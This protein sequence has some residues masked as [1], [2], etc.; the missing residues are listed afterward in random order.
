MQNSIGHPSA[1]GLFFVYV[2]AALL[3]RP[4]ALMAF[5]GYSCICANPL[6]TTDAALWLGRSPA[7]PPKIGHFSRG[8]RNRRQRLID[9]TRDLEG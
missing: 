8:I 7:M 9:F 5:I 4:S 1:G 6:L 2:C 3:V